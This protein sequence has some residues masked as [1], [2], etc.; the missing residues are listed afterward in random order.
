MTPAITTVL[1]DADGVLQR[2]TR[3]WAARLHAMAPAD[4]EA[5]VNDLMR[6]ERPAIV[7]KEDFPEALAAVLSRWNVTDPLES[8]LEPWHW[9]A[10]DPEVT[11]L[12]QGLR[13]AGIGCHL[14]TNQHAYR[15]DI[16]AVERNYGALFDQSFYSC[17]LGLA[18]PDPAYFQ[19]ILAA[20]DEPASAILFIDDLPA[21]VEGARSVGIHA[22]VFDLVATTPATLAELLRSYGLPS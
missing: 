11:A 1:F 18:K 16:M 20:V 10:A 13:A 17:D 15:R 22:E 5:F 2:G 12:I 21:N 7:G 9:F 14:A 19:A 3:D 4:G 6:S 8:A